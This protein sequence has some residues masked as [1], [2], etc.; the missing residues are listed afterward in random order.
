MNEVL[1]KNLVL[2][3]KHQ[4]GVYYKLER[5]IKGEYSPLNSSVE[6]I[7]LARQNDLVIN[8]MVRCGQKN[9]V[10]CDHEDP[11]NEAYAWIDKYIDASNKADIVFGMGMTF[12]LEVL[13]SFPNKKWLL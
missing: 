8:V 3:K 6:K 5:Y 9:Y 10:L 11:I 1:E 4:P 2:L 12:H 13:T 7:L